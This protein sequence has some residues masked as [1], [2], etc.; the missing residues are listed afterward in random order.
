MKPEQVNKSLKD[1]VKEKRKDGGGRE[2]VSLQKVDV[3]TLLA[4]T[5][6]TCRTSR[7]SA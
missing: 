1:G 2:N 4:P 6:Y 3:L 5:I 7:L